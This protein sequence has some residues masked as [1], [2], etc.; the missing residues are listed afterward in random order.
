MPEQRIWILVCDASRARIFTDAPRRRGLSLLESF[1]HPEGREH[2]RDLVTDANGRKPVGGLRGINGHAG[3]AYGRPGAEPDTTPKDVEAQKFARSLAEV[4]EKAIDAHR[5]DALVITAP[6]R[7]L[8]LLRETICEKVRRR[9]TQTLDKDL[10]LL[11]PHD[12]E[13]RL[14]SARAA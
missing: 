6:P 10:S 4:L 9:V 12:L 5:Y 1:E 8:G 13:K 11:P 2:T 3:A 14:R 7:F